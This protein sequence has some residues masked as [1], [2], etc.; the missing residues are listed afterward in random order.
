MLTY[1]YFSTISKMSHSVFPIIYFE[2]QQNNSMVKSVRYIIHTLSERPTCVLTNIRNLE[3]LIQIIVSSIR[4]SSIRLSSIRLS[5]ILSIRLLKES[6]FHIIVF[7]YHH[8]Y[9]FSIFRQSINNC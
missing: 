7:T 2:N 8:V 5:S 4:L 6:L 1:R 9:I 3:K